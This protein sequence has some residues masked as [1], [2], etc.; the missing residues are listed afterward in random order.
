MIADESPDRGRSPLPPPATTVSRAI[1]SSAGE[2]VRVR[3][4]RNS[5]DGIIQF[6]AGSEEP[7][8]GFE[9]RLRFTMTDRSEVAE[10]LRNLPEARESVSP[11]TMFEFGHADG[12]WPQ[13]TAKVD[14][15]RI[16]FC[17]HCSPGGGAILGNLVAAL[18]S[19]FGP[20]VV[21]EL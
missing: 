16:C 18:A 2:R 4:A 15:D 10:V 11:D 3:G 17:D 14:A 12:D 6:G 21:E 5:D 8:V 20:V 9:Y 13:A 19:G 1:E 7:A